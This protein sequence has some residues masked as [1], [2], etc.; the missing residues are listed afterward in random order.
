MKD[1]PES[2]LIQL[3]FR[4]VEL[5]V[6]PILESYNSFMKTRELSCL[7]FGLIAVILINNHDSAF[8]PSLVQY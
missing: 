3:K 8:S 4:H 5:T 7:D 2:K 6:T 1:L